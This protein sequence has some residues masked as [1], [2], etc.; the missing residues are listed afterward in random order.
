[1][2]FNSPHSPRRVLS[3]SSRSTSA[4]MQRQTTLLLVLMAAFVSSSI[5]I[6]KPPSSSALTNNGSIN[7][8]GSPLTEN[9]DT[10]ASA[11]TSIA[12][13]DNST[14]PGWYSTRTTYNSDTGGSNAGALYSFGAAAAA[15]RAL[16]GVA[17]GTTL[18][19]FF[20]AKLTNNTGGTISS[21]DISFMGEQ[22][23][24][25]G[26]ATQA[27]QTLTFQYQV[28]DA[29]TIT[30]ADTPSTGWTSFASLDFTS[31]INTPTA[32][33]LDGN[34]AANRTARAANLPVTV[35]NGQEIW[36]WWQDI[37][38]TGNDHG[39]A[40]DDLSVTANGGAANPPVVPTCPATVTTTSGTA[41][42]APVSASDADGTVTS[43]A[44]TGVT[45]S[46]PG[47]FALGGFTAAGAPG[48]TATANLLVGA[49]TPAG[50]YNVTI[51]WSNNDPIP[52]TGDCTVAVTVTAPVVLTPIHNIQGSGSS[53]PI[54]GS[55]VTTS[56]IVT[57]RRSNGFFIQEPDA[58]VDANP[59]TSEGLFVFT[60]FAPP[61]AAA[62][63]SLLQVTG[64]VAEFVPSG[65]PFSPPLTEISGSP[66][67]AVIS[68][69]NPLPNPVPL[70]AI[71]PD[72]AGSFDQLE[73]FEGMRV[74][75]SSL[76]VVHPTDGNVNE[77]SATSTSTGVFFGVVTGVGRPFRE[78]G[79]QAPDPAPSG[80]IPPIPRFDTNPE[81]IWVDSDAQ[82]GSA[83]VD[84]ATGQV[85]TGL[86]G[87]LD[88]GFRAYTILPDPA[89]PP[90]VTG[91]LSATPVPIP[92]ANQF[93]VASFNLERFFDTVNDPAKSDSVLTA[94]AFANR[95]NKAS[96]A[97]R[98]VLR[99]PDILGV[100]EM[101][102]L[103]TLQALAAK[104]S[105]D[106]IAAGQPDPTYQA[107]LVEGNDIGGIDVG[108]LVKSPP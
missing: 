99:T 12:W 15:E 45:P 61:A 98:N 70:T 11:G 46:D 62:L 69:G 41:A 100:V 59:A 76:T 10:L 33:A 21:L 35:N 1:M 101:E 88:Y 74:S 2:Y 9:F 93:T 91:S 5:L 82:P 48:G 56:G 57:G 3:L 89:S 20:A 38:D 26:N 77:S 13:T 105:A 24:N 86:V 28:A 103:T 32:G 49:L 39:L 55:T 72:P 47:T 4:P 51:R 37:N 102:N 83:K 108:F 84:V 18:T 64:T 29:G 36:L 71:F 78:P 63:G 42:S 58:T 95:L 7:A 31:P 8:F 87:P 6:G 85:V 27:T 19:I 14:I 79:I 54:A 106:A 44:V 92:S 22:W 30:D 50:T 25:G 40:V 52:Q 75:V 80:T 53:S 73:K 17:S 67:V 96:L 16:G 90:S 94:T 107:Y 66:T 23:R 81:R 97:I 104:I 65:D 60:S 43:A 68:T 34:A